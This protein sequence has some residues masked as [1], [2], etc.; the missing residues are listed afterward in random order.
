MGS[1]P[2]CGNCS[3]HD[4]FCGSDNFFAQQARTNHFGLLF[5]KRIDLTM[6]GIADWLSLI[7][8]MCLAWTSQLLAQPPPVCPPAAPQLGARRVLNVKLGLE[9]V[10]A[11]GPC[12]RLKCAFPLPIDWP[13]QKLELVAQQQS[14]QV[15]SVKSV[16]LDNGVGQAQFFVPRLAAGETASVVFQYRVE[17]RSQAPPIDPAR[18]VIPPNLTTELRRYLSTSPYIETGS[19]IVK[20]TAAD[21]ALPEGANAWQT[22][23]AIRDFTHRTIAYSGVRALKGA[24]AALED[25]SGDCEERTSVFVA[26]CRR[27]GIPARSVWIPL[28]AYAEFYLED[29]DGAGFWFPC[30]SVGGELG[31][32]GN[33][34]LILQKGD[35]FRDPFKAQPTALHHGNGHGNLESRRSRSRSET[36]PT[37]R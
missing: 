6:P 18:L 33:H 2:S 13:E 16:V 31:H 32:M 19:A 3:D 12:S 7:V 30:E 8:A 20:Q 14:P 36:G 15:R 28:H 10:A 29:S 22:V 23:A 1:P 17:R 9:V 26:L 24:K 21:L 11:N 37:G 35:N 5:D 34:F 4:P 27:H 25:R